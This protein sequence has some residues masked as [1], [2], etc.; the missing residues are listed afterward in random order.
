MEKRPRAIRM[1]VYRDP[2][3]RKSAN[4]RNRGTEMSNSTKKTASVQYGPCVRAQVRYQEGI[5]KE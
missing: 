2:R 4:V 1:L 3:S 5:R